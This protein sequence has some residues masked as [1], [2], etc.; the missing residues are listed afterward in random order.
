[1]VG[2]GHLADPETAVLNQNLE[3]ALIGRDRDGE[4]SDRVPIR[5]EHHVVAGLADR[6]A[7]VVGQ[8]VLEPELIAERGQDRADESDALR[9]ALEF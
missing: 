8:L 1:V 7:Q 6:G 2:D 4:R 3:P 5:V 9:P